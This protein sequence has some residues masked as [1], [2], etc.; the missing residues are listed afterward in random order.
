M[1]P[2]GWDTL[3]L[4]ALTVDYFRCHDTL[5][6]ECPSGHLRDIFEWFMQ[7]PEVARFL[8]DKDVYKSIEVEDLWL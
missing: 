5:R 6:F 3:L 1:L 4:L 7:E 8:A 2:K